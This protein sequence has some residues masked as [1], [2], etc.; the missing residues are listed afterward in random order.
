MI[1]IHLSKQK[2]RSK[3]ISIDSFKIKNVK[4]S[5]ERESLWKQ[6]YLYL[7]FASGV[8][9]SLLGLGIYWMFRKKDFK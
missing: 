7:A 1:L 2:W 4:N 3:S 5:K 9:V 6:P 8:G